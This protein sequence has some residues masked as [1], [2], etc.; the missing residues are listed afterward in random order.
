MASTIK[1]KRSSV[2]GKIPTTSDI[3]VGELAI[4]VKDQKLYSSNGISVFEIGAGGGSVTN[5]LSPTYKFTNSTLGI[6]PA[7]T[8][9]YDLA[10]DASQSYTETPFQALGST[11]DP[12]GIVLDALYDCNEPSNN[13]ITIDYGANEAYLGAA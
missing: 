8:A 12:F 10:K 7:A 13:I 4:N 6:P 3:T 9:N 2:A 11:T 5:G 1:I